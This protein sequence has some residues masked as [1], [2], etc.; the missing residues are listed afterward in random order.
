MFS[1]FHYCEAKFLFS[2]H[3][4]I[5]KFKSETFSMSS[6]QTFS[7]FL[8]IGKIYDYEMKHCTENIKVHISQIKIKY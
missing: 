6:H 2:I 4:L 1:W 7:I 8:F 5:K 3:L